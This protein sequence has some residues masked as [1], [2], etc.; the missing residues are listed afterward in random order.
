MFTYRALKNAAGVALFS[1]YLSLRRVH[2]IVHD[3]NERS[4]LIHA[5]E[6][7]FLGLAF[8]IRKAYEGQRLREKE[9]P[10]YPEVG[11]RL[12][13]Q[14]LWPTLLVQC[15]QLRDSFAFIDHG[16]EHQSVAYELEFIVE[17]ALASEFR[18]L[19]L[20]IKAQWEQLDAG[21]PFVE[22]NVETRVAQFAAWS[23]KER[24]AG[25]AGLLSSLDP[26]YP[27]LYPMWERNGK[28]NL[29]SPDEYALWHGREFPDPNW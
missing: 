23:K 1:D 27:T 26:M 28:D 16:K 6:G 29:V 13:F 25:L 5:K 3:V 24:Q 8:D 22:E 9:D 7:F 2:D 10:M 21:H 12:G 20:D 14:I 11:P 15:R 18:D 4:T 19:S 17:Q